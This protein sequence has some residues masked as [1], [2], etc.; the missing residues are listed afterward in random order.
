MAHWQHNVLWGGRPQAVEGFRM[1]TVRLGQEQQKGGQPRGLAHLPLPAPL[2]LLLSPQPET[3]LLAGKDTS[4]SFQFCG[5]DPEIPRTQHTA[6]APE[7]TAL[8]AQAGT[9]GSGLA[10]ITPFILSFLSGIDFKI[11]TI[12]LDGKRIKLQ[13]W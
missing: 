13:I 12:E 11:R 1:S 9:L 8:L 5:E 3:V 10:L 7:A 4:R 2:Q 6:A